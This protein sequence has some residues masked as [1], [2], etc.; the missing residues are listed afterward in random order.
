MKIVSLSNEVLE[1]EANIDS[2][3]GN[4][5]LVLES[6]GGAKGASN[7]RNRDYLPA[8]DC[9]LTRLSKI[10][11]NLLRVYIVSSEAKRLWS[12][13]ERILTFNGNDY[14]RITSDIADIRNQ[15]SHA[16]QN[17]KKDPSTKGG[18]PTKRIL[19]S[20]DL[21]SRTWEEIVLGTSNHFTVSAKDF[22]E[23]T[24]DFDVES[25]DDARS[26]VLRAIS[27]RR[28]QKKFRKSLIEAY[29]GKCAITQ[30]TII[31]LLEAAHIV[32]YTGKQT[33]HIQNGLL[34]RADIHTLFD[35]GLISVDKDF[36]VVVSGTLENTKEY[37]ALNGTSI[38]LP[39]DHNE[40]PSIQALDT[41]PLPAS[42]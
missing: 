29:D 42:S 36:R 27:S 16:Q 26:K 37:W 18:N 31:E 14:I 35:L 7:E 6:R 22:S 20:A 12:M 9:L 32:P 17:K 11:I 15:I 21:D 41:R 2:I 24:D 19:L 39:E 3:D 5:G 8:L 34:L 13:E 40:R 33:N 1:S 25:L 23:I 38:F 30:C 28:G 10:G 4:F